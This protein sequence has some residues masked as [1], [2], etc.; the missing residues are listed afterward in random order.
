LQV[1]MALRAHLHGNGDIPA[2]MTHGW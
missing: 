1:L 2:I